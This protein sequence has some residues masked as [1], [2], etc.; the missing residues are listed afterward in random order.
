MK[1]IKS[2]FSLVLVSILL[3]TISCQ[4]SFDINQDPSKIDIQNT[5]TD[6]LF[7]NAI[8]TTAINVGGNYNRIGYTWAQYWTR[9]TGYV[10]LSYDHHFLLGTFN[11]VKDAWEQSY[12]RSLMDLKVITDK[13]SD[14]HLKGAA[15][16]L[17]AYNFQII[18]DVFGNI[19]YTDALKGTD[20]LSPSYEN[21]SVIY[22]KLEV[23]LKD[24][25][26]NLNIA[27]TT[28]TLSE[29]NDPLYHG[30]IDNWIR[31]TNTLLLKVYVRQ[32]EV[33]PTAITKARSLIDDG[34]IFIESNSQNA[35]IGFT[36]NGSK[37]A[38]PLFAILSGANDHQLSKTTADI[39][40]TKMD[41]RIAVLYDLPASPTTPGVYEGIPHGADGSGSNRY[42]NTS[43]FIFSSTTPVFFISSWES[44]FLQAETL[45]RSGSSDDQGLFEEAVLLNFEYLDVDGSTYLSDHPYD[46][47]STESKISSIA[48]EKWA[49]MD[50][51]QGIESWIETRRYDTP[52]RAIFVGGFFSEPANN[53]ITSGNHFPVVFP[54]S[55]SEI[56]SNNNAPGQRTDLGLLTNRL[57]WDN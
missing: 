14:M 23:L 34:A 17:M 31:F 27:Q 9:T 42:S 28:E 12:S 53:Y 47:T 39:L 33:D 21:S 48:Y 30:N 8:L 4:K 32:F 6:E 1:N 7:T 19:P 50:G 40:Q 49:A 37:N 20:N 44:K 25:L 55:Q 38:N 24:A 15:Q 11:V 35:S 46:A 36:P 56:N 51:L 2:I 45:A 29:N 10:G 41:P 22:P 3:V 52:T 57:F 5:P 43:T 13:T 54:Y 26:A 16:A 18:T